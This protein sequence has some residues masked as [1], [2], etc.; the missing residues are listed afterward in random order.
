LDPT[1]DITLP[2]DIMDP[3]PSDDDVA[4]LVEIIRTANVRDAAYKDAERE[5]LALGPAAEVVL[6]GLLAESDVVARQRAGE[7][8]KKLARLST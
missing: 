8:L 6:K 2:R 4:R 1:S 3:C 5:L 7:L